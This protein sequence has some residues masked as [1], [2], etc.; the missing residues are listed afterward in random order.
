M[1]IE[2]TN[3]YGVSNLIN[4]NEIVIVNKSCGDEET[5]D[6]TLSNGRTYN[7]ISSYSDIKSMILSAEKRKTDELRHKN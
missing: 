6:I 1:F 3:K 4:L 7:T 5:A 2:V